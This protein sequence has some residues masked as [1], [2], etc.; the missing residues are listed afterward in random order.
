MTGK[1]FSLIV[2]LSLGLAACGPAAD[3]APVANAPRADGPQPLPASLPCEPAG[4]ELSIVAPSAS[5]QGVLAFTFD[6]ECLAAPVG[7]AL[8][9]HFRNEGTT[10]NLSIYTNRSAATPVFRGRNVLGGEAFT[11]EVG[12]VE[13]PG[14]Y[15]FRCDLHPQQMTGTFV[16]K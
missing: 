5:G 4:T 13:L 11:Y 8:K 6:K 3:T 14:V 10:H 15:F 1:L 9:I 2:A 7:E 12:P 16:V